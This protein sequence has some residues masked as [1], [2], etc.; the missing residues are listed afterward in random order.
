M[1][2]KLEIAKS[3]LDRIKSE[4]LANR[5]EV[6]REHDLIP[7][8]QPNIVGRGDIYLKVKRMH[9]KGIK[10][11]NEQEKQER[12]IE[13]LEKVEEFKSE[14]ELLKDVSVV[15][16]TSYANIGAKTSVNNLEYFRNKLQELEKKN[17]EAKAY[18]KTKPAVKAR[19]LGAEITKLKKK[20]KLLEDMQEKA[21]TT[22]LSPKAKE[23]VENGDVNQWKKKPI[24]YFVVGLNKV[25]LELDNKGNFI[26]SHRYPA[27][28]ESDKTFVASLLQ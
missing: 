25:A 20:I 9:A 17:E 4:M 26:V 10:L 2:T 5:K 23:L 18:N 15:G 12:R 11:L 7:F 3:K 16:K 22:E 19:T 6:R 21:E 1:T 27:R 8:G 28:S 24:Y 14:N 13:M